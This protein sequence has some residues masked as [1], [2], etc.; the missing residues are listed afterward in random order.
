M[1]LVG[2]SWSESDPAVTCQISRLLRPGARATEPGLDPHFHRGVQ[3]GPLRA[4][5]PRVRENGRGRK[6]KVLYCEKNCRFIRTV[7]IVR[8]SYIPAQLAVACFY[9]Q[10][11]SGQTLVT[12]VGPSPDAM[13][14]SPHGTMHVFYR[15]CS[16]AFPPLVGFHRILLPRTFPLSAT[17]ERNT[18][19]LCRL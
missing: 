18:R 16:A 1:G 5:R 13:L 3:A 11:P 4:P 17:R 2:F 19:V 12:D 8:R 14:P 9:T 10:R 7:V 6:E 15:A